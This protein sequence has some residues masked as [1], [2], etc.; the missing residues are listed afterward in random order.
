MPAAARTSAGMNMPSHALQRRHAY[1]VLVAFAAVAMLDQVS[2]RGSSPSSPPSSPIA[3]D[4]PVADQKELVFALCQG[5][6]AAAAA[7]S[8]GDAGAAVGQAEHGDA[9]LQDRDEG[10]ADARSEGGGGGW[11]SA[12]GLEAGTTSLLGAFAAGL[13]GA[14]VGGM[15]VQRGGWGV[16]TPS[17]RLGAPAVAAAAVAAAGAMMAGGAG[18]SL[19]ETSDA[20]AKCPFGFTADSP[21]AA[22]GGAESAAAADDDDDGWPPII[23]PGKISMPLSGSAMK[24]PMLGSTIDG[25]QAGNRL[26]TGGIKP[27]LTPDGAILRHF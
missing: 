19:R 11:D 1:A 13:V 8:A 2:G 20:P 24:C 14:A 16:S 15:L 22:G 12:L 21:A 4:L 25:A 5:H 10:R 17:Q 18:E 23:K 26:E 9:H 7:H 3:A 6:A 27:G